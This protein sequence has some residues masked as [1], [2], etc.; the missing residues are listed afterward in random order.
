MKRCQDS[1]FRRPKGLSWIALKV[2][3]RPERRADP[4]TEMSPPPSRTLP[5]IGRGEKGQMPDGGGCD[6]S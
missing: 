1:L 2:D 4:V 5:R 3:G 6:L